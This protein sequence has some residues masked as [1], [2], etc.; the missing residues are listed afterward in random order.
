MS[1]AFL[2]RCPRRHLVIHMDINR[3]IIQV[4]SAGQRTMED[5]LNGNIAA[6]VWG[7]CEEDKWVA[8][9][10]PGEE[11]DRSG[12]VT[13]DKYVDNAYTEP[14]LMQELP[15][16]EREGIWRDI[17]AKRRSVLRTF[18]HAGQPGE[19]Y[20]QH[21]EEQR[22]VL[23]AA[24]NCSMVPSFFQLVNTLSE[25]N[26]SFT[27][28]F[29]TFGHDLANVLQEWRQF[30]FGEL[31][32]KPQGALLGR[33]KEK[34]V[35]EMTGCIFRA[36]DSIFFCVGPDEAA[37]VHHPEGVEKMSPSE[38]LAQLSTM[39]S[40]KEVHQTNFMQLHD[41]FLEYTSASNNVGGIVDYYPFWAQGAERRSGGKVFPVAITS[42]SRVTAPV[43]PRF[44][45]FFDDNIFIGEEKS[46]VDLRDIVT[47]K[48]ITDAAIER[49]Y[50]V[51]V[52][53][54]KAT[55]D[56]EYFV[57]CLA[58]RIRLQLGED[59]ICID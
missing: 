31:A 38:V 57:D 24:S 23:T 52:N 11:G 58:G 41:Q 5:A 7:R 26:W 16:A 28:I 27:M 37:V 6:N 43:T 48:S 56:K 49:K 8:V 53:P 22:K 54:Y 14:P 13:F 19:N 40:C 4:D 18:T 25:L 32:H 1:R 30:L 59:E 35:P 34:Y 15:K 17:S 2:E 39:P 36:E 20:A 33:M 12:L 42:S 51:A 9:L 21:V 44:Y 3:T 45:V 47:G 50:C 10:G 55:V 29:R 46:I